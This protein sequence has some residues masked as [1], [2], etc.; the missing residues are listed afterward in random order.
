LIGGIIFI[1]VLI[2]PILLDITNDGPSLESFLWRVKFTSTGPVISFRTI[3]SI[4]SPL[5][6]FV[7]WSQFIFVR[8]MVRLYEHKTT[9][10]RTFLAYFVGILPVIIFS[11]GNTLPILWDPRWPYAFRL[12]PLP[13]LLVLAIV[14]LFIYPPRPV[15]H[16]TEKETESWWDRSDPELRDAH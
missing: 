12:T 2:I 6:L 13:L 9:G 14:M 3:Q 5:F 15:E 10:K 1:G 4:F 7:S 11:V 16:W 8:P